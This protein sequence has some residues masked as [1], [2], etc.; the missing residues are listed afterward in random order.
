MDPKRKAWNAQ[1]QTLRRALLRP[2]SPAEAIGLFL[3]QHAMV[4]TAR[5]TGGKFWSFADEAW[6]GLEAAAL[7]RIPP[8][9]PHSLAWLIW[10]IARIE[11]VT[12][13]RLVAGRPEVLTAGEGWLARLKVTA[14]DTGNGMR[15]ADIARLSAGIDLQAL[16]AYRLAV[17]RRTRQ[18][19]SRLT[20]EALR[21]RVDPARLQA[22][23]ADGAVLEA[24]AGVLDYWGGLKISG[25][26]LMPPTRHCFIHL[27]EAL[28]LRPKRA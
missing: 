27:N 26:L 4:H 21:Q 14:R 13:N 28:R 7:R 5:L 8:G 18:I 20:A 16:W 1:Q 10:H 19:V 2:G 12:L 25:V 3:A 9:S 17:G 6:Q 23:L 24:G 15:P 11:D 22:L